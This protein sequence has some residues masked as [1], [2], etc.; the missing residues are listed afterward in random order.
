LEKEI[1]RFV[2]WFNNQR[3]HEALDN[4]TQ[5][6]VYFGRKQANLTFAVQ[7]RSGETS[8]SKS[9]EK[10]PPDEPV[11]SNYTNSRMKA[12]RETAVELLL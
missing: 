7:Y 3:Y 2:A 8:D 12:E 10:K 11:S 5:D 1:K 9:D 4:V 6:D